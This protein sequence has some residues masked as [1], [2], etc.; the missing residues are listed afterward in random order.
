LKRRVFKDRDELISAAADEIA[1][2]AKAAAA[3]RGV[4]RWALAGGST[5]R[6]LYA[7][8]A[9]RLAR[10]RDFPWERSEIF[11]GDERCVPPG[12]PQSNYRMARES[13]LDHVPVPAA[14]VR[15]IPGELPPAEA[16]EAYARALGEEPLDLALLGMGADGHTASIFPGSP[17]LF[18]P[19]SSVWVTDSPLPPTRRISLSPTALSAARAVR[20]L[21][22]GASKADRVREVAL[23][24]GSESPALPAA[25]IR[26]LSGDLVW[27]LDRAAAA[28]LD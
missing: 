23:Q 5:P 4:F 11:F 26:P 25:Q 19:A 21:V 27:W 7:A 14:M 12:D 2:I 1:E 13:L 8:M 22:T 10:P 6:A 18:V 3:A 20:F 15:R 16:A 17:P 9:A 28:H 24:H